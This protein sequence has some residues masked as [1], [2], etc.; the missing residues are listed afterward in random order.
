LITDSQPWE[1]HVAVAAP[2][3][4]PVKEER[5]IQGEELWL[6]P[7]SGGTAGIPVTERTALELPAMLAA[8]TVLST[9]TA[10]LPLNVYQRRPDGGRIHRY[11]HPVEE[12][13]ALNP[14]GEGESTAVTWRSA[15]MGH[16][17]THGNG[18]AE[19]QRTGRGAIYGLH[20]LDP[21]TTTAT[22]VDGKLRYRIADGKN[23]APANVLHLAGLGYDGISGYS[24]IRLL[25]RAIGVGIAEE[26]YTADYF[27]NGSEPGGVV[28]TPQ[29]LAPEAVRTLRDGWE[30]RHGGPGKRHRLA[31]LQQGAKWNSTSTDPE[32]SQL[33]ESRK[34]QLLEVLRPWRVPPHKAGDFSQSHLA[35]IEASNLDYLMTALMYW[36]VAIEQQCHLKL[37]TPAE[38]AS[39]LYVEHNVNALLRGDIVSRFNAYHAALADG[40][41]NRDEIRQRENLNPIGEETGGDKFLVQL[42]QTTLE[43]IGE[44]ES[45]ET[46]AEAATE[47]ATGEEVEPGE[48]TNGDAS[49]LESVNGKAK[50]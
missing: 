16:T 46:P 13:L 17:L 7:W 6:P 28:E 44:D 42:N 34:Y 5:S 45:L 12:R 41:M 19:I 15:W 2:T 9:D 47:E 43:K 29:K 18:Y 30:G 27:Q 24:Y 48:S 50:E 38:R 31:V 23:L 3:P 40:W 20:L 10:V 26:T 14:D 49:T 32:K 4:L 21:A 22:R 8:L 35:N 36:L 11:D 25:R 33:I 1:T 37:F 39:G